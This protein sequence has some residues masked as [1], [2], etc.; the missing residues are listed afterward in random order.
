MKGTVRNKFVPSALIAAC[1]VVSFCLSLDWDFGAEFSFTRSMLYHFSHA[2][3]FHL[4]LNLV[5]LFRFCPRWSTCAV[6]FA[7]ASAASMLP[8]TCDASEGTCGLSGFL[9]ASYAR[10]YVTWREKPYVLLLSMFAA[11]L[12]PHVNWKIHIV[13][14]ALSYLFYE[15]QMFAVRR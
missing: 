6:A 15:I 13:S 1:C 4:A 8:F 7:C 11:G 12:L 9:F 2:N 5:A 14:F 3:I 10:R